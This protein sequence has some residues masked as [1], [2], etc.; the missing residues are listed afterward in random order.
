MNPVLR[1]F[2]HPEMERAKSAENRSMLIDQP[3]RPS[4]SLLHER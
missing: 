2:I 4:L 1:L 3:V